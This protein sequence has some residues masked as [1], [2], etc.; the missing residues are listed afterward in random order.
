MTD[1]PMTSSQS[2]LGGKLTSVLTVSDALFFKQ[3]FVSP[4]LAD[5]VSVVVLAIAPMLSTF[6]VD[7]SAWLREE[8]Y[9]PEIPDS[10]DQMLTA[11][12]QQLKILNDRRRSPLEIMQRAEDVASIGQGW[13]RGSHSGRLGPLKNLIQPDLGLTFVG[14]ELFSTTDLALMS[15]GITPGQCRDAGLGSQTLGAFLKENSYFLGAHVQEVINMILPNGEPVIDQGTFEAPRLRYR[16]VKSDRFYTGLVTSPGNSKRAVEILFTWILGQINAA[17]FIV[18][19]IGRGN[20]IAS[21][22]MRF[23]CLYHAADTLNRLL[24]LDRQTPI[25]GRRAVAL[26]DGIATHPSVQSILA[27]RQLRNALM[28]Y[29]IQGAPASLLDG[30]RPLLGLVEAHSPAKTLDRMR[31][32]VDRGLEV[33]SKQLRT[34]LPRWVQ[35]GSEFG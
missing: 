3:L 19:V 17:R 2:D 1:T 4:Q 9:E 29:R 6:V 31:S 26:F 30:S 5:W 20:P 8:G 15:V 18:P 22:K 10:L 28:H 25:L 24:D 23:V 35:P 27:E 14:D 32:D 34:L 11:S 33:A 16:D 7:S 21:F 12:R 13:F